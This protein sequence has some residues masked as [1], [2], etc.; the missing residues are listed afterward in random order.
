MSHV[1]VL[2]A[3]A[4]TQTPDS[5]PAAGAGDAA[6]AADGRIAFSLDGDLWIRSAAGDQWQAVTSGPARD[7]EPAWSPTGDWLYFASDRAGQFDVWRVRVRAEDAMLE[8]ERVTAHEAAERE[9]ALAG[10]ALVFVRD[11]RAEANIWVREANGTERR[12]IA[13]RSV[14]PAA[15]ADGTRIAYVRLS[16][17]GRELRTIGIDGAA[18]TVVLRG[19]QVEAPAWSPDGER[20]L[21]ATRRGRSGTWVTD[22]SGSYVNQVSPIP[23]A[24]TWPGAGGRLVLVELPPAE[25][26]YNGDPDRLGPRDDARVFPQA[27]QVFT[28]AAPV[29]PDT[30]RQLAVVGGPGRSDRNADAFERIGQRVH[31]LY[32]SDRAAAAAQW[33]RLLDDYRPRALAAR[34]DARLREVLHELW[35]ARPPLR[36]PATGR[37]AISSAH[38]VATEA[39]LEILRQGGNAVDAA[40]AV[41][42]ALGVVE[43]D[44]SGIGGYGQMLIHLPGM[45]E[46]ELLEFMSTAPERATLDNGALLRN[47]SYPDDG[48]VLANVPGTVAAMYRAW[49]DHGSGDVAWARLLEPAIR[50]AERG[51]TVSDG[52]ATTL[53]REREHFLKYEGS[54]ALFFRDG[55]PLRA[56]DTVKNPDLAWTLTQ[57]AAEGAGALY[58]GEVGRRMVADLRAQGNVMR[59]TDLM[60]YFVAPREPVGGTYRGHT[61]YSSA[62]P[63]AGGATLIAKLNLL[64]H[65]LEPR[66]Y[67]EDAATLH[68]MIEAWKLQPSTRGKIADPGFWPVDVASV[69]A[70]DSAAARWRCFDPQRAFAPVAAAGAALDCAADGTPTTSSQPVGL[71]AGA[72]QECAGRFAAGHC[73]LSGTTAFVVADASGAIVSVT[74]TLGTWGGNFYVSPGLGFIY[75]DKLTSYALEP[76]AYGAR[77]PGARHGSSISPTIIFRGTGAT[78]QPLAGIG[79]A[80]NAWITAA[81]YQMAV[82]MI[83][84]GLGPQETLEQPRF[85]PVSRASPLGGRANVVLIESGI[86]PRVMRELEAIGHELRLISVEGELRMGYGAA[87][88]LEGERAM[89]GGDPRR[90]G[91]AGAIN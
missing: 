50:A 31:D 82:A 14:A 38:P 47:G 85:L 56:G 37:A 80:G 4:L 19:W 78:K 21:F 83:D 29:P 16:A 7:L 89:A 51:Y 8:P 36:E 43:P 62:P 79:A 68:A 84:Y 20:L 53:S 17:D 70:K 63:S 69:V 45:A 2:L 90:S 39:G 81:V 67:A 18:D 40:I 57:L 10:E 6:L 1:S 48:P 9:P 75:N 74:Q 49:Q 91:T 28:V 73:H 77:R 64:E 52:L 11:D 65:H 44:A 22:R 13:E 61:L 41:S 59:M 54:R 12:L 24:G 30:G 42:F 46:P 58:G 71:D 26:A 87:V 55:A 32:F 25:E 60:R 27:G 34:D 5:L 72:V 3:I 86:A 33:S 88:K 23:A 15:T 66:P 35:R 76:E